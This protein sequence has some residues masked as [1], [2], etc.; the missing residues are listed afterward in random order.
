VYI[1]QTETGDTYKMTASRVDDA[2]QQIRNYL[3]EI[4]VVN[5]F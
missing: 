4:P 3:N 5:R 2:M 1:A